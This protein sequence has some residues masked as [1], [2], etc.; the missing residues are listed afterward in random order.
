VPGCYGGEG[1]EV[2]EVAVGDFEREDVRLAS[3]FEGVAG[4][5]PM[6]ERGEISGGDVGVRG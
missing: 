2:R 4:A 1:E 6:C 5:V 3:V